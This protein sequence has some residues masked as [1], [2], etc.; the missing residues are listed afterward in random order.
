MGQPTPTIHADRFE[1]MIDRRGRQVQWQEAITCSCW[2]TASGQPAYTCKA[3]G[4]KG[5][6]YQPSITS[7]ALVTSVTLSNDW[8]AMA[9]VFEVGD[10]V[11]TIPKRIPVRLP[12]GQ[13]TGQFTDN[14]MF[15]IGQNDKIVLLDDEFKTSEVLIKNQPIARR[16]PDTLLNSIITRIKSLST[17]DSNTGVVTNYKLGTDYTLNNN[18]IV[19]K[20]GGNAPPDGTQY[21][22][23]YFHR[24]AYVVIASLPK[25]RHQ[26]GQD[27]PRYV[28]LRYL[29]GA[30]EK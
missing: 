8:E 23:T 14:P 24:P 21:S 20:A 18:V 2:N 6:I 25:P 26:D 10:A 28:A 16:N 12:T 4:G 11:A 13:A 5:Y 3:C 7:K 30:V 9:G 22:V 17:F 27:L 15:E 1:D 29:S 19:W